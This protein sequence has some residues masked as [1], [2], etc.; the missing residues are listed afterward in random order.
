MNIFSHALTRYGANFRQWPLALWPLVA[1]AMCSPRFRAQQRQ[2]AEEHRALQEL[3]QGSGE[4]LTLSESLQQRLM[5]IPASYSQLRPQRSWGH[6]P[7]GLASAAVLT[8]G[9]ALGASELAEH[10][11]FARDDYRDL[12]TVDITGSGD[13]A[14]W[15]E[16]E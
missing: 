4:E 6:L 15:L 5:A 2:V 1:L 11:G 16:G 13:W 3:M 7:L 8:L 12:A 9:V 14:S 10:Y